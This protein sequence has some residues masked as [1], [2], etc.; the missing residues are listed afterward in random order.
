MAVVVAA[1]VAVV[2]VVASGA[3]AAAAVATPFFSVF[4]LLML[5]VAASTKESMMAT[6]VPTEAK[7]LAERNSLASSIFAKTLRA[8]PWMGRKLGNDS[9]TGVSSHGL[10]GE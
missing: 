5:S 6:A 9:N 10:S 7:A 8:I 4:F 3:T 1:V 2:V